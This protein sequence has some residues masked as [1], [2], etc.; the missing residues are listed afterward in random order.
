MLMM[1][2]FFLNPST[3]EISAALEI[4]STFGH[5][6]LGLVTNLQKLV[7]YQI[8]CDPSSLV[9]LLD[10]IPCEVKVFPCKYLGMCLN[11]YATTEG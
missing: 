7:L 3:Q 9:A 11:V 4:L 5:A 2:H 1:R 10:G 6:S 8:A